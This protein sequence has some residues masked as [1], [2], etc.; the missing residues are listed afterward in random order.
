MSGEL[1]PGWASTTIDAVSEAVSKRGPNPSRSTFLYIDLGAIDN[2]AKEISAPTEV[3]VSAAPSRAKQ[4]VKQGDIVFSNV[5]VYLENI[6]LVPKELEGEVASTAFCVLRPKQGIDARYVYHYVTSAP[7]IRAVSQ[8]QRGN[9]PPS[10]QDGDVKAQLIPVAP[11]NEQKRIVSKI[12]ELFSRIDEG[13]RALERVQKLVER[14]RQSVLK[15]AV[16]G[17]LTREWREKHKGTMESGDALL[18]RILTARRDA[19]EKAELAKMQAKG[20]KPK[21][22][23]WK[24]KYKEPLPPDTADLPELPAGWCW[25]SLDQAT[26]RVTDGTHQPPPFAS[27][28]IPFLTIQHLSPGAVRWDDV[29]KCVTPETFAEHTKSM[30]PR[31][32]DVLYSAVGSYGMAVAV[33][34][35]FD[36]MFQRHIAHIRPVLELVMPDYLEL[37]LNSPGTLAIAHEVARGVAQKTVTLGDL[38]EF[39]I[40]MPSVSEQEQVLEIVAVEQARLSDVASAFSGSAR[41]S[42]ALRQGALKLAFSGQLVGQNPAD[43]P[44]STLLARI[45]FE[46]ANYIAAPRR[47]RK[48]NKK[49]K[50]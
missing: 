4:I 28:G 49:S 19:W 37:V 34:V 1:P 29:T 8:L 6:A 40:P 31:R 47:S 15:A 42:R 43:E 12:D 35:D 21:D 3:A 2:K 30:R 22:D 50:K 11:E 36:F 23:N 38:R 25:M 14:Y 45:A 41:A 16:T 9:S 27:S 20:I 26:V 46:R 24:K 44:A 7:F 17:E 10:V 48:N 18:A 32:G 39:P 33:K 13:E 5:R